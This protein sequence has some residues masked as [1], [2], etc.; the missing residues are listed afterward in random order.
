MLYLNLN[1]ITIIGASLGGMLAPRAAAFNKEIKRVITWSVFT[2]FSEIILDNCPQRLVKI[3]K[4][5]MKIKAY[6]IINSLFNFLIKHGKN[7]K[8]KWGIL[9]GM[10][11]YDAKTPCGYIRKLKKF[12]TLDIGKLIYQDGL[13]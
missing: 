8:V 4:F 12:Q 7:E 3:I 10:Y 13:Y 2:D 6:F 9:H 11:A 1:N 5:M